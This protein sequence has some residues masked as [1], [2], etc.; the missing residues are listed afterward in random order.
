MESEVSEH[1]VDVRWHGHKALS[2]FTELLACA[3][4][5]SGFAV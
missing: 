2:Q 4:D 3:V 5:K 1:G